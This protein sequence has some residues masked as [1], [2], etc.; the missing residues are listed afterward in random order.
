METEDG[1]LALVYSTILI[2][3]SKITEEQCAFFRSLI[4]DINART[5]DGSAG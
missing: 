1:N 4:Q 3:T 2:E 5:L